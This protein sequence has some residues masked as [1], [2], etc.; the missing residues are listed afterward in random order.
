MSHRSLHLHL[1]A[2]LGVRQALG[3]QMRAERTLLRDFVG[4]VESQGDSGPI[5]AQLAVD[6][7]CA[8]SAQRGRGG[9]AQR[10]SMARG[11]LA[12]LR[13]MLPE[14]EVPHSGL[15]ASCRRP[16]PYLF[17]PQQITRLIEAAQHGGPP[18]TLRPATLST[19]IGVLA[20]TGLRVG[21][22]IRLTMPDV[23]LDG[24]PPCLHIRETKYHKSRLVPLHPT[25][26]AHVHGYAVS[27]VA[28]HYAAL[29]D[30][31]F[32]SEQG[33]PLNHGLLRRWF[34]ALC[35]TVGLEPTDG[36]HR[37]SLRALRHSFAVQRMRLWY[38][39]G[40]DVQALLPHLSVYLGHVRP[41][42]SYWYLTATPELL[43]AAAERFRAY[44]AAGG[45]P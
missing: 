40:R 7:A 29:S 16:Q 17:T 1:D 23:R 38:Q 32:V 21:E 15:V 28:L 8:S 44:A 20:S 14:T 3:F 4:F 31:F 12:Y 24:T 5:R 45:T 43:E 34:L 22:A 41:Q 37:P 42:E 13:T 26:A 33:G 39:E 27:R 6:W 10:L 9:A 18:G 35:H 11:F 25:T 2:Y 36:G 30:L 19:L